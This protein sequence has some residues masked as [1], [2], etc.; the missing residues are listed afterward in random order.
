MKE[1]KEYFDRLTAISKELFSLYKWHE[2]MS[3]ELEKELIIFQT[4]IEFEKKR[5]KKKDMER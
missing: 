5:F 3:D 1:E 4:R 2:I